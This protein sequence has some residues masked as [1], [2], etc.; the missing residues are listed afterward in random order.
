MQLH[1]HTIAVC[2]WSL[3]PKSTAELAEKVTK[4]GISHMQLALAELSQLDPAKRQAE[5]AELKKA[6]LQLTSGMLHFAGEDY[7]SIARIRETGGFIPDG[8]WA[9]RKQITTDVAKLAGEL[10]AGAILAH[11][12][13][14]PPVGNDAYKH[15]VARVREVAK[16][17]AA[18]G[19]ALYMETGQEPAEE[20]LHF[21]HD[22][23]EPNVFINFDPANM[24]LYGAGEPI[25]AIK[26]LGKHIRH[27]H[28]KDA[29]GSDKPGVDWGAE[30]PFGT[31]W[32]SPTKF[33]AALK[34]IGYTGPLSIEREAGNDR[35]G[36]IGY[37]VETLKRT[38][39]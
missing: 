20:L 3:Q 13:F 36:D 22:L 1:G 38:P 21:M 9:L 31:G 10:K 39:V 18:N 26:L 2:S 4:L 32:V 8:E 35:V 29:T 11:V 37:A 24:I 33:L 14:V 23:A 6:T 16:I 7:S 27:V 28:V 12:G 25:P 15:A 19:V 5:L 17:F 34:S 30:V